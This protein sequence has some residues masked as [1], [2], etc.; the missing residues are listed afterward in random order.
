MKLS[1]VVFLVA[2]LASGVRAETA[3]EEALRNALS[4]EGPHE[5][6][7]SNAPS[8]PLELN[9]L[10]MA[11][12]GGKS[13][14]DLQAAL[15]TLARKTTGTPTTANSQTL[16]T[17]RNALFVLGRVGDRRVL[18]A[19]LDLVRN[20]PQEI[21]I[22]AE[23]AAIGIAVRSAPDRIQA[24]AD[25]LTKT[26]ENSFVYSELYHLLKT[27]ITAPD[28][29]PRASQIL[30]VFR[31]GVKN[32]RYGNRIFLDRVL[33][34]FDSPYRTSDERKKLLIELRRSTNEIIKIYAQQELEKLSLPETKQTVGR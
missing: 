22:P 34:E 15:L 18:D 11:E 23:S 29:D 12:L 6:T 1:M 30:D 26:K 21:M 2:A 20:A 27:E 7:G 33:V 19:V 3:F 24:T 4:E 8:V 5:L 16:R 32:P 31:R 17:A 13:L 9:L 28:A 25:E 14:S 10:K